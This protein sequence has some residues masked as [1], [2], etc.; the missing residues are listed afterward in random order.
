MH[1]AG[2]VRR[3]EGS[4]GL[5]REIQQPAERQRPAL[6]DIPQRFALNQLRDDVGKAILLSDIEN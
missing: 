5:P 3:R 4:R 1:D 2:R 6:D